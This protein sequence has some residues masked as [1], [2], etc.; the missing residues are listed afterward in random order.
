MVVLS[1][2]VLLM[3][4]LFSA[5][6]ADASLGLWCVVGQVGGAAAVCILRPVVCRGASGWCGWMCVCWLYVCIMLDLC[7]DL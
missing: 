2:L 4:A 3:P 7:C 5:G 6:T 1:V